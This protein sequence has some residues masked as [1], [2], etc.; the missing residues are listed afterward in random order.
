[1]EVP[2]G[3]KTDA[4]NDIQSHRNHPF[5]QSF[6]IHLMTAAVTYGAPAVVAVETVETLAAVQCAAVSA[7]AVAAAAVAAASPSQPRTLHVI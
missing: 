3:C 7:F 4:L 5:P 6:H 1:M 2:G